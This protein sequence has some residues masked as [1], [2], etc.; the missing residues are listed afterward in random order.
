MFV[1]EGVYHMGTDFWEVWYKLIIWNLIDSYM[2]QNGVP[3]R[4]SERGMP[5]GTSPAGKQQ[6][7]LDKSYLLTVDVMNPWTSGEIHRE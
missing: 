5:F 2:S 3:V 7:C 4:I 1:E 6:S